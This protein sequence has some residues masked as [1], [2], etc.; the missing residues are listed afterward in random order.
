MAIIENKKII[1]KN[2]RQLILKSPEP[3][4]AENLLNH[5]KR[6]FQTSYRNMN[7]PKNHWQT[8]SVEKETE[9]LTDFKN[10]NQK[11]MISAFDGEKIVGNLGL[12]GYGG[13][14]IKHNASLGMGLESDYHNLGLGTSL[15]QYALEN[16][17]ALNIKRVE[18][19]VRTFNQ[20]GIQLYE[21]VGFRRIGVLKNAAFIDGEY[22]DECMYEILLG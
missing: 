21:K 6:L 15:M 2:G 18:L 13:E 3:Q 10:S 22:F 19:H 11:F 20:A 7:H 12:F 16:A 5:L 17:T 9:I 4:D 8:V 14:F 1:L